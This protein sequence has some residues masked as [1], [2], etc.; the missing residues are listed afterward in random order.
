MKNWIA[1]IAI[2]IIGLTGLTLMADN[3][4]MQEW[5]LE[6]LCSYDYFTYDECAL[7]LYNGIDNL[8]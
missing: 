6:Q 5:D 7:L 8:R 1:I 2:N 4:E 3:V